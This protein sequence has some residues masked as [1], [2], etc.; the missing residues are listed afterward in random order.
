MI[1]PLSYK[2]GSE[3]HGV[4]VP[5]IVVTFKSSHLSAEFMIVGE[6]DYI[7]IIKLEHILGTKPPKKDTVLEHLTQ[8]PLKGLGLTRFDTKM[9]GAQRPKRPGLE[10]MDCGHLLGAYHCH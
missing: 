7:K 4:P 9:L 8:A 10:Q 3:K 5:P 1:R 6:S 2:N